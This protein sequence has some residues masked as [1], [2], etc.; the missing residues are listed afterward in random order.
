ATIQLIG[1]IGGTC[2][3]GQSRTENPIW[4]PCPLI[5]TTDSTTFQ[6]TLDSVANFLPGRWELVEIGGGWGPNQ[7]PYRVV[8]LVIN[9]KREGI[10]YENGLETATFQLTMKMRLNTVWFRINQQGES[11]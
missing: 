1:I 8:E 3:W 4:K 7:K 9:Q 2:C 11:L 10:V 6:K 5:P